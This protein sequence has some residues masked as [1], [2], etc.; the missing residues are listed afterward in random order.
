[1]SFTLPAL[2]SGRRSFPILRPS[3]ARSALKIEACI[4]CRTD[5]HA[6]DGG[7]TSPK[8]P[9]IPGHEIVSRMDV[10]GEPRR[11]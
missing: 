6:V 2:R 7:L 8:L 5:L 1:M 9:I 10:L 3:L 11:S 4:V